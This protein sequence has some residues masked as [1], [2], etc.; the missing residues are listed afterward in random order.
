MHIHSFNHTFYK[1]LRYQPCEQ[2]RSQR[3]RNILEISSNLALY[4]RNAIAN[5]GA[6]HRA[7]GVIFSPSMNENI[8]RYKN[9]I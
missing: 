3:I 6:D 1:F 9:I 2:I 5:H 7:T 4:A 8:R